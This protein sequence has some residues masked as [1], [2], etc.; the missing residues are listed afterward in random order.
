M[1][2]SS[3]SMARTRCIGLLLLALALLF[4]TVSAGGGGDVG[5]IPTK[6]ATGPGSRSGPPGG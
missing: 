5:T 2:F 1:R 4:T 3:N 6:V